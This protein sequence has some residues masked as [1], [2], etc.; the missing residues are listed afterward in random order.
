MG[1][2]NPI[3]FYEYGKSGSQFVS[4]WNTNNTSS[5]SSAANQIKLPLVGSGSYN[6]TVDWGDG[7]SDVITVWNQAQTTH[8]YSSI[9]TYQIKITG[10]L[11]GWA[12]SNTGDR[13]KI[14]SVQKWG[15]LKFIPAG[16]NFMGCENLTLASVS[17][18]LDLSL[19]NSLNSAFRACLAITTINKINEWN[20][21]TITSMANAFTAARL[22]NN[23]IGAWNVSNVTTFQE[24]FQSAFGTRAVFNNGGS[25]DINNWDTSSAQNMSA[26]FWNTSFN[27]PI[28]N[29]NTT[30]VTT[31]GSMFKENNVFNQNIGAWNVTKVTSF[32]EMFLNSS[33]FNNGGSPTI[34]NWIINTSA[35]VTMNSMF[36]NAPNFNQNIGAWDVSRVTN[37]SLMFAR[38]AGANHTFNNGG[39]NT[40]GNWNT[41][42]VTTMA[43]MFDF[44]VGFNQPI[45]NWN[46]ANVTSMLAM[47]RN[48]TSFN[49][50]IGAWNVSSVSNFG[51]FMA[52]KTA[53]NYS[54]TNLDAI[55]NGWTNIPLIALNGANFNT[56]K[57]TAAA[58]AA[59]ALLTRTNVTQAITN[60]INNG[61]GLIR[62]TSNGHGR[63]TG[64][65][66]FISGV[67]GTTEA[68]GGWIITVIDANTFDLQGSTF[69]NAYTSA[70]ILRIGYGW[71]IIDGGI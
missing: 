59:R 1:T 7:S 58:T 67:L 57:Y 55:Y 8:T 6:F 68:N 18:V 19:T 23:N 49:Q 39:S 24:M 48:A 14:L 52:G 65:K 12:F 47:F 50:D 34:G 61:S 54:T 36:H 11:R 42:S 69:T 43:Q 63:A 64:D 27:Q 53:A 71:T 40:I 3:L 62:I 29:W 5:G 56:I 20:T 9:G 2:F 44:C 21:S 22:F 31:M 13:L 17:D 4:T 70:G 51:N 38:S 37:M 26:M 16:G 28:G 41:G 60:V 33:V 66:I 25:P 10:T 35:P 46:V 32:T 30:N 15:A 45:N